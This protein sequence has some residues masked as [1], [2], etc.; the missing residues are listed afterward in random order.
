MFTPRGLINH[1]WLTRDV[2]CTPIRDRLQLCYPGTPSQDAAHSSLAI[3][4]EMDDLD[5]SN[6]IA[7]PEPMDFDGADQDLDGVPESPLEEAPAIAIR[8]WDT[9][10][11]LTM[12]PDNSDF[13]NSDSDLNSG[14]NNNL[15]E[16]LH[17]QSPSGTDPEHRGQAGMFFLHVKIYGPDSN[18]LIYL[19]Q[20][21]ATPR[22]PDSTQFIVKFPGT[23]KILGTQ[24]S[25]A[26]YQQYA[27]N[28]HAEEN[29]LSEWA[30][31]STRLEWEIAR[32][33][34]LRG[35]SSTALSELLQIDGVS[36]LF[37]TWFS[38]IDQYHY[39]SFQRH[40][41]YHFPTQRNSTR[42]LTKNFQMHFHN[43]SKRKL[44]LGDKNMSSIIRTYL[45]V[46]RHFM[47]TQSWQMFWHMPLRSIIRALTKSAGSSLK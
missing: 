9:A 42:S 40:L 3:D 28:F 41:D 21:P 33:A 30:P 46:S 24:P 26:G 44:R 25:L 34:K 4:I 16:M 17:A 29:N 19:N 6:T 8:T 37:H 11:P 2:R 39:S 15:G 23:G 20:P 14:S 18:S 12:S 45:N 36:Q 35:P 7:T 13:E 27:D 5:I 32:W 47:V 1:L 22:T 10:V 31:F 43:L 38:E